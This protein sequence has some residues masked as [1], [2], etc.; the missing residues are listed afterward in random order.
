MDVETCASVVFYYD[1]FFT[2]HYLIYIFNY[3]F[4]A[5]ALIPEKFVVFL[6]ILYDYV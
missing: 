1:F 5:V 2:N 3:I 4:S 6:D